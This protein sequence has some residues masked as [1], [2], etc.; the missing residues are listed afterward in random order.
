M[1][2]NWR[3]GRDVLG[4]SLDESVHR[5]TAYL[6]ARWRF[7]ISSKGCC[8]IRPAGATFSIEEIAGFVAL[9][10]RCCDAAFPRAVV[11]NWGRAR[12]VGEQWT[13]AYGLLG[14][15][16]TFLGACCRISC[17]R[18]GRTRAVIIARPG[19]S[20]RGAK[21]RQANRRL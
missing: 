3:P 2:S 11:F 5:E 19:R 12:L 17:S 16:A 14:D 21:G 13:L 8:W 1:H 6:L 15:F 18:D 20:G 4:E 7:S 10:K 9:F